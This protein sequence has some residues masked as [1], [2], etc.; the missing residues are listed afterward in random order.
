MTEYTITFQ[1]GHRVGTRSFRMIHLEADNSAQ[2]VKL[3]KKQFKEHGY[4][5]VRVDHFDDD[6]HIVIDW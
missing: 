1:K 2:A 3:A 5:L 4:G 6:G